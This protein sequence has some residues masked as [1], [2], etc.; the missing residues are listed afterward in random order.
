MRPA[1]SET[2]AQLD[3]NDHNDDDVVI[4]VAVSAMT[5]RFAVVDRASIFEHNKGEF[6]LLLK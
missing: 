3:H 5:G 6:F 2:H 1:P 4:S